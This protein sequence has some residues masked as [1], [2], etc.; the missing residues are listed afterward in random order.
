MLKLLQNLKWRNQSV[1]L[2]N[3]FLWADIQNIDLMK[4]KYRYNLKPCY[5]KFTIKE[6]WGTEKSLGD[7]E[8][9]TGDFE[10]V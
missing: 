2:R 3:K 9:T 8:Y 4:T 1:Q 10:K 6:K 7:G 5:Q